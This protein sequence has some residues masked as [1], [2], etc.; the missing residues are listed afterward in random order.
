MSAIRVGVIS[1][2]LQKFGC[3]SPRYAACAPQATIGTVESRRAA[4]LKLRLCEAA[5]EK[6]SLA[7]WN[8]LAKA[9]RREG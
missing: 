9:T 4:W 8:R 7:E 6:L 5:Q 3:F 2:F 1:K